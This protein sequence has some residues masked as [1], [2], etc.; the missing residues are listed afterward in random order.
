MKESLVG[1]LRR[2]SHSR[3]K[4]LEFPSLNCFTY[5][6]HIHSPLLHKDARVFITHADLL[7]GCLQIVV[8]IGVQE[9][10]EYRHILHQLVNQLPGL[11]LLNG[12]DVS[13]I[14]HAVLSPALLHKKLD[15][16]VIVFCSRQ[17]L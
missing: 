7:D 6:L 13:G 9:H 4:I 16:L 12:Q 8:V 5:E 10:V 1:F 15:T 14:C 17:L 3:R 2:C 11:P